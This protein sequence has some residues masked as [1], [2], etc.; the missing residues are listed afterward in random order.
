MTAPADCAGRTHELIAY[1]IGHDTKIALH[2]MPASTPEPGLSSESQLG[3]WLGAILVTGSR[4]AGKAEALAQA[5]A[6]LLR[7]HGLSADKVRG[8]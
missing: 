6:E 3:A 7:L 4:Q 2:A 8:A 1:A 5:R